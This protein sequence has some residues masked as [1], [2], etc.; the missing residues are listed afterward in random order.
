VMSRVVAKAPPRE[1]PQEKDIFVIESGARSHWRECGT[2][3]RLQK[4]LVDA[5]R[6]RAIGQSAGLARANLTFEIARKLILG[7]GP[8]ILAK[9]G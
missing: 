8:Q 4:K 3:M 5:A 2:K 6:V 9:C 7:A 1:A